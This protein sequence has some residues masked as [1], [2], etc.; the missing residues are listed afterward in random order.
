MFL[1]NGSGTVEYSM[2]LLTVAPL[3]C[4]LFLKC[5]SSC[6]SLA[7][8]GKKPRALCMLG[9][10]STTEEH[11]S[12]GLSF[13]CCS[14]S[15][16][17]L[18]KKPTTG[19]NPSIRDADAGGLRVQGQPGLHSETLSPKNKQRKA[20]AHLCTNFHYC[21]HSTHMCPNLSSQNQCVHLSKK[22]PAMYF[23]Q[24]AQT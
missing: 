17:S 13:Q 2:A 22:S 19:C 10:H 15:T 9:K 18:Q 23:T 5:H 7:V 1:H 20:K 3:E 6:P 16:V 24:A 11:P 4:L 21:L 12:P 14:N 8:L